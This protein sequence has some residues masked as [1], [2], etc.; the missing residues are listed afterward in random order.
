[1]WPRYSDTYGYQQDRDRLVWPYR[2]WVIRAFNHNMPYDE[3]VT[4]QLAGD[5]LPNANDDTILATT[6]NRLHSQKVEGG[7]VPEEFRVEYVA[8]RTHT[9]GTAFL[10]LTLECCRCHDHKYDPIPQRDYYRLFAFFQ[11]IDEAGLYSWFTQA[12]PTPTLCLT[13]DSQRSQQTTLEDAVSAAEKQLVG[14]AQSDA[15]Q[16][17]Y[18]AWLVR[19][20]SATTTTIAPAATR[21]HQTVS[22]SGQIKHL[23]FEKSPGGRNGHVAGK[24]GKAVKLTGDDAVGV[25]VGNFRRYQPF[26]ISLWLNT[27]DV[28]DRAVV[29]HRSRAWTDA[30]SRGY[31]LLI[32]DGKLSWSLIHFWPGNAIRVRTT[33]P[34]RTN[35]WLHV[36][37]SNDGSSQAAGLKIF[38]NGQPASVEV[39]RNQ[40]TKNITGGGGDNIAV[41]ER[42]R[43]RGF[44]NGLVDDFR[45]FDRELSDAEVQWLAAY[46]PDPQVGEQPR[47]PVDHAT[48]LLT[49]D[50][51]YAR[52][53]RVLQET[54][55][56]LCG[57]QDGLSEIMVMR[58]LPEPKP[59]FVLN[60]GVYDQRGVPV[61]AGVPTALPPLGAELSANRL[62]LAK[63]LTRP[64]QPLTARV[65]VN[66]FWQSVFGEGLVR[67][68][69]DF[70]SQGLPPTHPE[71]LDWLARD[72]IEHGWDVK[73][74]MKQMVMSATYQQS[75]AVSQDLLA[76]DPVNLLLARASSYRLSAEQLRD[77]ALAASGLLVR[78]IGGPSVK[79]V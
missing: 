7:S 49:V 29:F 71:L 51:E 31:Q 69:E 2:D 44:T 79:P 24:F 66:R 65:A 50:P 52:L 23:D 53:R 19:P 17:A 32:E 72:F 48:Y 39:V 9:F 57:L 27:P 61:T 63:W 1:M 33:A 26:A 78:T 68:P 74:L 34:L 58:E 10:G 73:R 47:Q 64:D 56:K 16:N 12:T 54:R 25:G 70:G 46:N 11:N 4:E 38:I 22:L 13:S 60:R 42:F 43:D 30:A 3:F 67:T 77:N 36:V 76:R 8:D 18:E 40:L 5:L 35:K 41:G 6:F 21:D 20:T 62:G 45:V 59:A 14:Y 15:A 37:V 55:A 28:K 75:S